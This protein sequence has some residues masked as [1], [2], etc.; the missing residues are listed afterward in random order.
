MC[1]MM[2]LKLSSGFGLDLA[3]NSLNTWNLRK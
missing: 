1:M 3:R 2:H